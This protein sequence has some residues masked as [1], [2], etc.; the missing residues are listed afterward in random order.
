ML[1]AAG[2]TVH[3]APNGRDGV[4]LL[5]RLGDGI[6]CIL[7]DLTMPKPDG[8]ETFREIRKVRSDVPVILSSGYS[9]KEVSRRFSGKDIAG[10]LQKPYR[11]E[12]LVTAIRR[13]LS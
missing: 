10:F 13:A 6:D 12:E 5:M 2:Y 7:L 3:T 1:E 11:S 4:E 8:E 9:G